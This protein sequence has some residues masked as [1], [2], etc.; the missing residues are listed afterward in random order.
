LKTIS[1]NSKI[2]LK[3]IPLNLSSHIIGFNIEF[4]SIS[5]E[6]LERVEYSDGALKEKNIRF[7]PVS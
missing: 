7:K 1:K 3:G 2:E 4:F 6:I 5:L